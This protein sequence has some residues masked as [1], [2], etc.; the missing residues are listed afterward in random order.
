M[1]DFNYRFPYR[2]EPDHSEKSK[3][4]KNWLFPKKKPSS[5]CSSSNVK[6]PDSPLLTEAAVS[7]LK[8]LM[9]FL[10]K[11][12]RKSILIIHIISSFNSITCRL[13]SRRDLSENWIGV[14]AARTEVFGK[15]FEATES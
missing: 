8:V 9:R 4:K 12:E 14:E 2:N 11:D 7:Q 13:V 10:E 5:I 15:S 1:G 6:S 3:T